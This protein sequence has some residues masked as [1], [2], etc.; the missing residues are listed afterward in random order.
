[1]IG[2]F[3]GKQVPACGFALGLERLLVVMADR[4]L[5]PASLAEL[6]VLI[7]GADE[8]RLEDALRLAR[9]LR[10]SGLRVDLLP[11]ATSPGKLRKQAD[12]RGVATA[13]W[14][15]AEQSQGCNAWSKADGQT[16]RD[17]SPAALIE[18]IA[19]TRA[20]R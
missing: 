18:L 10:D 11:D 2:M 17:L 16:Q 7:A 19:R 4:G 15:E 1:L 12:A 3:L 8:A 20:A 13:A 14:I 6:D 9:T 5:Y